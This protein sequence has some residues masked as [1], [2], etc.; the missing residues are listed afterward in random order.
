[1]TLHIELLT[2]EIQEVPIPPLTQVAFERHY[3]MAIG[4]MGDDPKME[5]SYWMTWHALHV[6]RPGKPEFEAWLETIAGLAPDPSSDTEVDPDSDPLD[7][8][9][10]SGVSLPSPLNPGLG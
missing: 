7:G 1:M 4:N 3:K 2:G 5:Y 6:G 10:P 8:V 9:G